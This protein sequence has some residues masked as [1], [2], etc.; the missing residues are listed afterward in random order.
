MVWSVMLMQEK[1]YQAHTA[2]IDELKHRAWAELD[3]SRCNC[4]TV[5]TQS[6]CMCESS[7]G[8]GCFE[9]LLR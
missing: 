3:H 6:Q 4:R 8:R 5:E 2:N 7:R 9:H 1:V